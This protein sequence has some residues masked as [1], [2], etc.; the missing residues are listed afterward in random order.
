MT[1]YVVMA[2]NQGVTTIQVVADSPSDAIKQ[3]R[4]AYGGWCHCAV[5][6]Q[7]PVNNEYWTLSQLD[8]YYR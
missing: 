3:V 7:P 2:I 8:D 6:D 5:F 4:T 1:Y